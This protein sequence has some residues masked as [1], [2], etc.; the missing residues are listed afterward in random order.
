MYTTCGGPS[1]R[2]QALPQNR[3]KQ[4]NIPC[5]VRTYSQVHAR[6]RSPVSSDARA[7]L[8]VVE[9]NLHAAPAKS[10]HATTIPLTK[11]CCLF[12]FLVMVTRIPSKTAKRTGSAPVRCNPR[13]FAELSSGSASTTPSGSR[14]PNR[15]DWPAPPS[16]GER[17]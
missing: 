17:S 13:K 3:L 2:L 1:T 5:E 14:F 8:A 15:L 10:A 16:L 6:D 9:Q 7:Y 12:S 11:P 4:D